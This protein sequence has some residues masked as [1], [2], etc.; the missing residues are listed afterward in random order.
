M[1]PNEIYK[2]ILE[3]MH[4]H[5]AGKIETIELMIIAIVADGHALLEGVP[6]VAKTTMT[7]ALADTI[8]AY[9]LP[10]PCLDNQHQ[11]S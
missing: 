7:K 6:G 5:I 8:Q 3:E 1:N 10:L 2:E 11:F 4:K 9:F